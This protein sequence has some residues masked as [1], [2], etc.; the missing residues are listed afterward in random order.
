VA[1]NKPFWKYGFPTETF[2][3]GHGVVPIFA[4]YTGVGDAERIKHVLN[5]NYIHIA[6][7]ISIL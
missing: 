5:L 3:K 2:L 1:F 7:R 4:K 6:V